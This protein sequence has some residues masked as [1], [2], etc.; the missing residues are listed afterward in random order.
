MQTLFFLSQIL[1]L[2]RNERQKFPVAWIVKDFL[3]GNHGFEFRRVDPI[4][5]EA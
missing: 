3:L 4:L 1:W 5:C 2:V